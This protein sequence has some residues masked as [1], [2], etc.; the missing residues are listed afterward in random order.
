MLKNM[1]QTCILYNFDGIKAGSLGLK[2][3]SAS[4]QM[5]SFHILRGSG[6]V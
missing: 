5:E 6:A 1:C 3:H 2:G 4:A